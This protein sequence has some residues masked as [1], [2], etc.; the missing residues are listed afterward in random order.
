V[1][2]VL[3]APGVRTDPGRGVRA[4]LGSALRVVAGDPVLW[5]LG[6]VGFAAR[7]GLMVLALP[8]VTI[9]GPVLLSIIF[10]DQV[11]SAEGAAG[12]P[13]LVLLVACVVAGLVLFGV[14][15]AAWAEVHAF[16]RTSSDPET[17][18][19]RLGRTPRQLE[20]HDRWS[21]VLWVAAVFA[22]GLVPI[23]LTV[24]L[25]GDRLGHALVDEVQTP[26]SVTVPLALRVFSDARLEL[27][28]CILVAAIMEATVSLGSRRLMAARYGVLPAGAGEASEGR[29]ALA[30]AAR[31]LRQPARS[32]GTALLC[33]SV[34]IVG[35]GVTLAVIAVAWSSTRDVLLSL[36]DTTAIES[37]AIAVVELML[38]CAVWMGGLVV[39]GFASAL[40]TALWTVDTLR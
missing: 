24:L 22:A 2:R 21:L 39:V 33:W 40:R 1:N 10:R 8:I 9:P 15:V 38:F 3:A 16:E 31:L 28:L 14:L 30:G 7:G 23:L 5:L 17:E 6:L 18:V 4:S 37:V 29:T 12:S 25:A 13:V 32:V 36:A 19:L 20:G 35:V 11:T 27:G 34:T 26:S